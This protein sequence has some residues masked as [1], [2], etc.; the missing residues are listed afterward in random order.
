MKILVVDDGQ[1]A[2]NSLIRILCRV[3]PDCDYVSAMTTEDALSW[4]RQGPMDAAFLNLEMPGMNGLALTRMIQKL[5]PRCNIIV[6]TEHPEYALEALQIFVSGF[7]LKPAN[8]ADVRNVLEHLR[9]PP[10]N[11]PVGIKIQCFGNFEIFVGGR[12]LAFKRSKSKELLAYLVDRNGATC[13]NGE[14]LAVL[15]EDKPDTASLHSH[16]RNLIFDLSH[17]LEDAGVTGLLIRGRSTLAL[18]TSKQMCR[19]QPRSPVTMCRLP[20]F[21]PEKTRTPQKIARFS[22]VFFLDMKI[23]QEYSEFCFYSVYSRGSISKVKGLCVQ[24]FTAAQKF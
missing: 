13:T 16:L 17:T 22:E 7:L 21:K 5:Q 24:L 23:P 10:E 14:M 3:A 20:A 15:W 4:M 2:I 12:A 19:K 18:D 8:E 11:A 9:Y 1:L 6:V